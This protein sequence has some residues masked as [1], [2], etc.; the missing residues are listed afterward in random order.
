MEF[1]D[2]DDDD[3]FYSL[4]I[5]REYF[6]NLVGKIVGVMMMV[7]KMMEN[8]KERKGKER[9]KG[10]CN[11]NETQLILVVVHLIL[12]DQKWITSRMT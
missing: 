1:S 4:G 7:G 10:R 8:E 2:T 5:L 6:G 3:L 9:K 11:L 12:V